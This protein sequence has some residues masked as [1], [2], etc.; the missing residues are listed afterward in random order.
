MDDCSTPSS[1]SLKSLEAKLGLSNQRYAPLL[2]TYPETKMTP[3]EAAYLK[4]AGEAPHLAG[5]KHDSGKLR[6]DLIPLVPLDELARAYTVG[7]AK[8]GDRNYLGGMRWGRVFR[9]LLS[10]AW[11]WWRGEIYDKDDGQHHLASVAWCA[12]TLIEY[13]TARIGDDDR[14]A[15]KPVSHKDLRQLEFS[16]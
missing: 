8:Y 11:A 6:Y 10:H 1:H 3:A 12:F 15:S 9:A 4:G 7:A 13:E 5:I 14:P 16:L 2:F